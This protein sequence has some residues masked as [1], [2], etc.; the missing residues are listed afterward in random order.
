MNEFLKNSDN[1]NNKKKPCMTKFTTNKKKRKK[2][3]IK[4]GQKPLQIFFLLLSETEA[5]ASYQKPLQTFFL[6]LS[7]TYMYYIIKI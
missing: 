2:N 4:C 3:K 1:N 5:H 6:F 7:C